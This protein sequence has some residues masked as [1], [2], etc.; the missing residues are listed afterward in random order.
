MPPAQS[1]ALHQPGRSVFQLSGL[2]VTSATLA[3]LSLFPKQCF[4][5][6]MASKWWLK[7]PLG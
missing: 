5:H 7:A 4:N 6:H 1:R 3:S 2:K